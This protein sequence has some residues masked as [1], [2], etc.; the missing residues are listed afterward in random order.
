[1]PTFTWQSVIKAPIEEVFQWHVRNGAFQRLCPPWK[2]IELIKYAAPNAEKSRVLIRVPILGP[3]RFT[4]ELEHD[5][6][7]PPTSFSD[8]QIRGPFRSWRHIH[9]FKETQAEQTELCDSLSFSLPVLNKPLEAYIKKELSR[10]FTFRHS[11]LQSDI[12]LHN[13]FKNCPRQTILIA[14]ASGFIGSALCAFLGTAGHSIRKLVRRKPTATNEFYWNPDEHK[15]DVQAFDGIDTV[16]NLS[17]ANIVEQRWSPSFKQKILTSRINGSTLLAET[18]CSLSSPPK[19]ALMASAIGFYGDTQQACADE[20]TPQGKGFLASTGKDWESASSQIEKTSCRLV[21]L[22]I[23]TVLGAKGG[24]LKKML[25]PFKLGFGGKLGSGSQ[26][27][28]W[29]GLQDLLGIIEHIIH[30]PALSG[31]VNAVS[32][33]PCTNL[34]FT[35]VLAKILRRPAICGIPAQFLKIALGEMADEILL[36]NSAVNPKALLTSGYSFSFPELEDALRFELG[37]QRPSAPDKQ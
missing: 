7:T 28:S 18:I 13:R 22:R 32:P 33:T 35:K 9:S 12:T 21:H 2:H 14:G 19:L 15:I 29:I 10:L 3:L 34:E 16:I 37:I 5:S 31:A 30:T 26:R 27:M 4:W 17:G 6:F 8:R 11:L 36:A 24:A 20:D 23:G 25:L 1:M